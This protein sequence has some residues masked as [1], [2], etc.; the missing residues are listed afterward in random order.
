MLSFEFLVLGLVT[1]ADL[2]HLHDGFNFLLD[3]L[4][5]GLQL[6]L[7]V[8]SLGGEFGHVLTEVLKLV[9]RRGGGHVGSA[10]THT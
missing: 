10:H 7:Q 6:L 8:V 2:L 1:A 5:L 4:I 9:L 3:V